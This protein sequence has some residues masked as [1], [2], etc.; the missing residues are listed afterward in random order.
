[1]S[2]AL[3]SRMLMAGLCAAASLH[4]QVP[5]ERIARADREPQ[6]WLTY[7]GSLSSQRHSTLTLVTPA[8]VRSLGLE[9]V[10]QVASLEKF[11]AT[12]LVVDGVLYSVQPPNDIFALDAVTGRLFW[13][14]SHVPSSKVRL[15]CGRVNR[16]VAIAGDT[17]FL[18]TLDARLL[19]VDAKS[20]RPVW[21]VAVAQPEAGYS[22]T[23]APLVIKDKVVIGASGGEFGIRG[24]IA[25]FD[26]ATGKEVWR[27]KTIP[28][29]GEPGHETWTGESWKAGGAPVWLTG[30]YDPELNLTYWGVGNPGPDFNGDLRQGANLY[31]N[32][33]VALD[34]DTGKLR[35]H[36]QFTP[37]DEFDYDAVQVPVLVDLPWKGRPRRVMLWANR[38][39]F[40]YVLD[41]ATGEFLLGIPFTKVNWASG[42]NDRGVPIRI[43]GMTPSREGTRIYPGTHGATNWFSPSYSPRTKLFYVP[44]WIDTYT[45]FWKLPGTFVEGQPYLGGFLRTPIPPARTRAASQRME[46]EGHGAILALDPLTGARKWE[47]RMTDVTDSGVLTTASNLL[48]TG[49]REGY[50]LALDA[51]DGKPLWRASVGGPII[52]A[53]ITYAVNGR[54]Y[55]AVAAGNALFAFALRQPA[56]TPPAP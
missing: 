24:F 42:L 28:E 45:D 8:N 26:V 5:F 25:A 16:G 3:T 14:Y 48:F 30:S 22:F 17:L 31:S 49:S 21:N 20:G 43:A 36:F 29:P 46:S 15:C 54:Q 52:A 12:P 23:L 55:V 53:P 40:F 1:M 38:N 4:A 11:E 9:W 13:Q 41:R 39:G 18:A 32:S 50:F 10:F 35:W 33:V 37:H 56:F 6:N 47:F 34:A 51:A 44:A 19:A 2:H 27:F 7:S